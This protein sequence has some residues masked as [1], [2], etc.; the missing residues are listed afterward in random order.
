MD[1]FLLLALVGFFLLFLSSHCSNLSLCLEREREREIYGGGGCL[2]VV[3]FSVIE[4]CVLCVVSFL[5][6]LRVFTP[7]LMFFF[8][9]IFF[10]VSM[11]GFS[12]SLFWVTLVL[13]SS[14]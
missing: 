12:V 3:G 14:Y 13:V 9:L 7:F 4:V 10:W 1:R 5:A 2:W 11:N 6:F 8:F